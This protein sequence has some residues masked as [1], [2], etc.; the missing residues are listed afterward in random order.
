MQS[1]NQS[2]SSLGVNFKIVLILCE[3][4]KI[5]VKNLFFVACTLKLWHYRFLS[6]PFQFTIY[7]ISS[8]QYTLYSK[9]SFR[10]S[11]SK[12]QLQIYTNTNKYRHTYI[13]TYTHV[14]VYAQVYT[15]I[16]TY[17]H[18]N[19]HTYIRTYIHTNKK[20][21]SVIKDL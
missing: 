10:V 19:V 3:R 21:S 11:F 9:S 12:L 14:H 5:Q 7:I 16:S 2:R 20:Q 15:Y 1:K 8:T 17:I 18:T 4:Y 6:H 13:C